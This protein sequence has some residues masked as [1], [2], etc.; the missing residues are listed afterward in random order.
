MKNFPRLY[1]FGCASEDDELVELS[2]QEIEENARLMNSIN[3]DDIV[4]GES[5][6]YELFEN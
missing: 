6:F 5:P 2:Q 1:G 3:Y 4:K